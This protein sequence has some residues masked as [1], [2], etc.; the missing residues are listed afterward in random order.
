MPKS[1]KASPPQQSSL[2]EMW[3]KKKAPKVEPKVEPKLEPKLEHDAMEV[4]VPAETIAG[5]SKTPPPAEV[6]APKAVH[7]ESSKRKE[8]TT[9]TSST[10]CDA[11]IIYTEMTRQ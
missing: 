10:F 1:I 6:P 11:A 4:D 3:G 5:P 7:V 2:Q 9:E 8:S